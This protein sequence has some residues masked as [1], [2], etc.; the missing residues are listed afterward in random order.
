LAISSVISR[1]ALDEATIVLAPS[2]LVTRKDLSAAGC[3]NGRVLTLR[4]VGEVQV[5]GYEIGDDFGMR[6]AAKLFSEFVEPLG[7]VV[8][9]AELTVSG[10]FKKPETLVGS[11][12]IVAVD[13]AK[14]PHRA[15]RD[16]SDLVALDLS[17]SRLREVPAEAFAF[18]G[19]LAAVAFPAALVTI[20]RACFQ[21]CTALATV[22]LAATRVEEFCPLAFI[23]TGLARV[24]LPA[25]FRQLPLT[26][27]GGT[28]LTALDLS[29]SASVE[30]IMR[31]GDRLEVR[32]LRLPREGFAVWAWNLLPGSRIEVLYADVDASEIERLLR[33]LDDWA[34]DRLQVVSP[35]LEE[36]FQWVGS[37]PPWCVE[38]F[39]PGIVTEPSAVTVTVWRGIPRVGL[40]FVQSIDLSMVDDLSY[41]GTLSGAFFLESVI[42]SAGLRVLPQQFFERCPR[43]SHVEATGRVKLEEIEWHAFNACRSLREFVFPLSI[44]EVKSAFGGTSIVRLDLTGTDAEAICVSSMKF[45]EQLVLPRRCILRGASGLPGLRRVTFGVCNWFCRWSPREVR[46]EGLVAPVE[47]APLASDAY[48][49]AEV[50]CL[51]G[52]ESFPFPP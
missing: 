7:R 30:L 24:T 11:Y 2:A 3:R 33:R 40:N 44:R 35:R 29:A 48:A 36:P 16:D 1:F 31:D 6:V 10:W 9:G 5:G 51:L 21:C 37:S 47:G 49:F 42:L 17:N 43:L 28:R 12:F 19:R 26:A 52:R 22:D 4:R 27:L 23:H 25:S 50:A 45:L 20:G 8:F 32:E 38:V 41:Y 34:I 18:C 14:F 46:M 13:G 15:C 39:D